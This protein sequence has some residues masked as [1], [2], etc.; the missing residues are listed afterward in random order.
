MKKSAKSKKQT[1]LVK[2]FSS[3]VKALLGLT[4]NDHYRKFFLKE[5]PFDSQLVS[6]SSLY[7]KSREEYL[8][9]GGTYSPS[10][11]S[12]MR[13]L[14][15]HDLFK[16][17][18]EFTPSHS[19]MVWLYENLQNMP[20]TY[21]QVKAIKHFHDISIFHEQN[22]RI[23]WKLLPPAPI[24]QQNLRRYLNFAESLV[25]SL[26]LAL[27]DQVHP[28]LSKICERMSLF[29]RPAGPTSLKKLSRDEYRQYLMSAFCATYYCLEQIHG[30][31]ILKAVNYVL[32]ANKKFN[33]QAV[34][35]GLELNQDFTEITNPQ[36]QEIYWQ[37]AAVKLGQIHRGSKKA[38]LFL[39]EDPLD[40]EAEF[41]LVS[42]IFDY[43]AV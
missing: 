9:L 37:S 43:F 13:S 35:R 19:E 10:V 39:P 25:V 23:I 30:D 21:E 20:D 1:E 42:K 7:R 16:N 6:L 2:N 34:N 29:Y 4:V 31:D 5:C 18:I 40:L 27:A 3:D 11:V 41:E 14:S 15:T 26:D 38:V 33:R 8:S 17:E 32:P 36:W 22:H 24:D 12:T 28:K